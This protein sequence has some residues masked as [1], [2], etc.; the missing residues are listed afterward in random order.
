MQKPVITSA[1]DRGLA[2]LLAS[3]GGKPIPP[4]KQYAPPGHRV[5]SMVESD[6]SD[7]GHT[8]GPL[9]AMSMNLLENA[10]KIEPLNFLKGVLSTLAYGDMMQLAM[11]LCELKE[12]RTDGT[13]TRAEA[14][15][16]ADLMFRWATNEPKKTNR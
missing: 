1:G 3:L 6:R 14:H 2:S 10:I 5:P 16:T 15:V 12:D 13:V 7:S 8:G 4:E 11:E 9:D